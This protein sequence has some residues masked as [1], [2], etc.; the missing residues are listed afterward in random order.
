[1]R[2]QIEQQRADRQADE[3]GNRRGR[4]A[5]SSAYGLTYCSIGLR[6]GIFPYRSKSEGVR[7]SSMHSSLQTVFSLSS[8]LPSEAPMAM[9]TRISRRACSDLPLI[10]P[11]TASAS[12]RPICS[13]N[14][15]LEQTRLKASITL[16]MSK[17]FSSSEF[18]MNPLIFSFSAELISPS[19]AATSAQPA[20]IASMNSL[21][22][23]LPTSV[24][25]FSRAASVFFFN[26]SSITFS[27]KWG[28]GLQLQPEFV[29]LDP[30]VQR[31]PHP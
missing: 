30:A 23:N 27:S 1:M 18:L 20:T 9:H 29:Y 16:S 25:S 31:M 8:K 12:A 19:A 3:H 24:V 22:L 13:S 17:T 11:T 4:E 26:Q 6:H 21:F 10:L 5:D 28:S 2:H 7:P 15:N 14:S